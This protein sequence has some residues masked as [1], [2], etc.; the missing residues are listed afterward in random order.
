MCIKIIGS[1][2]L[3]FNSAQPLEEQIHDAKEIVVDYDPEDSKIDFFVN[4]MERFCNTGINCDVEIKVESNNYL[5]GIKLER[6]IEKIKQKINVN[7]VVKGL[8][9]FHYD[10][11]RKLNE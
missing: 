1:Q 10:V 11:D 4:E 2:E 3:E 8:T 9:K 5:D 6:R 7:E